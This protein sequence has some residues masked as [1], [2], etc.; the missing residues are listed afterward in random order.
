VEQNIKINKKREIKKL[1]Q[2]EE[3]YAILLE[4]AIYITQQV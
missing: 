2:K 1:S 3:N 4:K